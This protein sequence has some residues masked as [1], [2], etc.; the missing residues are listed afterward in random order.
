MCGCFGFFMYVDCRRSLCLDIVKMG[1][2]YVGFCISILWT[3]AHILFYLEF[4]G[5][6]PTIYF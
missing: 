6:A 3:F 2:F 4:E 1:G 5:E